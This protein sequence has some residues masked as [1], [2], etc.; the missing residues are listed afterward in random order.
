MAKSPAFQFYPGDWQRDA[1]LKSCSVGARGCWIEMI[2]IMHQAEPYGHLQ[3]NGKAVDFQTLSRMIGAS[4]RE[5]KKWISE[6]ETAGVFQRTPEGAIFSKR[7]VKDEATRRARAAGGKL[8]GNPKL[9]GKDNPKVALE[10]NLHANL[11]PTPSS[12]SSSSYPPLPPSG[13]GWGEIRIPE[14]LSS[15]PEFIE[16]L[17]RFRALQVYEGKYNPISFQ[18]TIQKL[19]DYPLRRAVAYLRY[20][21]G[22]G[23][24]TPRYDGGYEAYLPAEEI[25]PAQK[26]E[27]K[28]AP[29][30]PLEGVS[31]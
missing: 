27:R 26:Q 4:E 11:R 17:D 23:R 1:A 8:G 12:S 13:E 16:A 7:M 14:N 5:T 3:I 18:D 29:R 19:N 9:T 30:V 6:L 22:A 24:W 31:Q 2:C 10:V 21:V 25:K 20:W 15:S 28:Y